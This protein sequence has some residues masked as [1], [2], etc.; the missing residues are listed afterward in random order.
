MPRP[1]PEGSG[2]PQ[3]DF[4]AANF[5]TVFRRSVSSGVLSGQGIFLIF[6]GGSSRRRRYATGSCFAAA[7]S[8][9]MKDSTVNALTESSTERHHITGTCEGGLAYSTQ[10]LGHE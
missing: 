8:S 1:L 7:A 3:P 2:L 4:S 9:S 10:T 6:L 5:K